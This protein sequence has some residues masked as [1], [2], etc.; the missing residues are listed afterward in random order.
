[1]KALTGI[2]ITAILTASCMGTQECSTYT[3]AKG[4]PPGMNT[5]KK[6]KPPKSRT[7][8]FK[9]AKFAERD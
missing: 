1:M 4:H 8:F 5:Y 3:G 2:V 9:V 7:P 6:A